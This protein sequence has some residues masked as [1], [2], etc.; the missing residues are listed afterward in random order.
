MTEPATLDDGVRGA[1]DGQP[2]ANPAGRVWPVIRGSEF[3]RGVHERRRI[4]AN[5]YQTPTERGR[6]LHDLVEGH[7]RLLQ[8]FASGDSEGAHQV[9]AVLLD[10][11]S[12]TPLGTLPMLPLMPRCG[13]VSPPSSKGAIDGRPAIPVRVRDHARCV[14]RAR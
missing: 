1:D 13:R 12:V 2:M 7:S 6:L 14:L 8:L 11:L 4:R 10:R 5:C 9:G 3:C